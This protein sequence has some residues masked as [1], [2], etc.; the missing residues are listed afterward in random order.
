M[1]A[2]PS[3][4]RPTEVRVIREATEPY[5]YVRGLTPTW[6]RVPWAAMEALPHAVYRV[7][8]TALCGAISSSMN[9]LAL[10]EFESGM[11]SRPEAISTF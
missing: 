1:T 8:S 7:T 3:K 10:S 5:G 11:A 9:C 4:D 6:H 2:G